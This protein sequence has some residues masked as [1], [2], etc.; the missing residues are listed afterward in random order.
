MSRLVARCVAGIAVIAVMAGAA[1][2][3]AKPRKA[4]PGVVLA[5]EAA[6]K[7]KCETV[8]HRIF[9]ESFVGTECIA[10]YASPEVAGSDVAILY[11]NGDLSNED[12][13][14]KTVAP[15][16]IANFTATAR[17]MSEKSGVRIIFIA[18]PGTFGS[19]GNHALRGERR[20]MFVMSAA[21]DALKARLGIKNL[22]VTGQSRGSQVAASLLTM[23][24]TDI[25][26]VVL[27]SGVL[28]AIEFEQRHAR[29]K[30][31][32][33]D[34]ESLRG[35]LYDPGRYLAEVVSDPA[36]RIFVLGDRADSITHFD[37]QERFA[38][39]LKDLGHHAQLLEIKAQ[40]REM[41][42][43]THMVLPAATL[44][45]KGATDKEIAWI[46]RPPEEKPA[47]R[48]APKPAPSSRVGPVPHA[49]S[50]ARAPVRNFSDGAAPM[51]VPRPRAGAL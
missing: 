21:V 24:R 8:P 48:E 27:G 6:S 42:G 19:S 33:L 29:S 5:E 30:G 36:R 12:L 16:F 15:D 34:V 43:A 26:C 39:E 37:L 45:A 32:V 22:V 40:G 9:V 11:F 50:P 18:R 47:V 4:P 23:R 3:Q 28:H 46:V 44:C 31:R 1:P 41:H 51:P 2:A 38:S 20:E 35:V 13:A 7:E 25:R 14:D 10:F 17:I 49:L